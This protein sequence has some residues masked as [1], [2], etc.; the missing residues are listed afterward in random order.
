M[1]G[2]TG[3]NLWHKFNEN[4]RIDYRLH[5]TLYITLLFYHGKHSQKEENGV[6][7]RW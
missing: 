6:P 7:T 5:F 3:Y 4:N 1:A 2:R